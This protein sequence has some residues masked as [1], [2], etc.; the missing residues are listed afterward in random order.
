MMVIGDRFFNCGHF[1]YVLSGSIVNKKGSMSFWVGNLKQFFFANGVTLHSPGFPVF[2]GNP[3]A[4]QKKIKNPEV[5]P[6]EVK[7][8]VECW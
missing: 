3:G 7:G 4:Q 8:F 5:I 2:Q 1:L 6:F